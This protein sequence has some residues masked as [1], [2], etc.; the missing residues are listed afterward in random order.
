MCQTE[1]LADSSDP[2]CLSAASWSL[3][4]AAVIRSHAE[5]IGNADSNNS[6]SMIILC[7]KDTHFTISTP[8][9]TFVSMSFSRIL[10]FEAQIPKA[11]STTRRARDSLQ[12]NTALLLS[13]VLLLY[14]YTK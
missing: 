7:S 6:P 10:H 2:A 5:I 4:W 8:V 3:V 14:G 13:N 9:S 12:L 11:L 1:A